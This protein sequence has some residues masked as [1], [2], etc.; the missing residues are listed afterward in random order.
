L[1]VGVDGE[2]LTE[3]LL[4]GVDGELFIECLLVWVDGELFTE[5]LL[6]WVDGELFTECLLVGVDGEL[7]TEC[8]LVGVDGELLT[9]CLLVGVDGEL[10]Q[11]HLQFGQDELPEE[12]LHVTLAPDTVPGSQDDLGRAVRRVPVHEGVTQLLSDGGVQRLQL[13]LWQP[14]MRRSGDGQD[15]QYALSDIR[16]TKFSSLSSY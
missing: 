2:L 1:L 13:V 15:Q 8:L 16:H 12:D 3:C 7:F 5:C 4:V 6:V 10:L 9:E 14:D 11:A